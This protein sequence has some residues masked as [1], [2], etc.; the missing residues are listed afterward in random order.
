MD[1]NCLQAYLKLIQSLL[2]SP[3]GEEAQILQAWGTQALAKLEPEQAQFI[4]VVMGEL[5]NLIQKWAITQN[6]LANVYSERI[7]GKKANNL[8]HAIATQPVEN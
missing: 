3:I 2:D 5:G 7:R 4:A 1:E 8:E 6:D